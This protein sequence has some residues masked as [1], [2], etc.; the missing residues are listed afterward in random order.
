MSDTGTA[1]DEMP[2]ASS[3]SAQRRRPCRVHA[4]H[5]DPARLSTGA[6]RAPYGCADRSPVRASPD[7]RRAHSLVEMLVVLIIVGILIAIAVPAIQRTRE[8]ARQAQC[9]HNQGQLAKAVHLHIAHEPYGR[10][11]G[12]RAFASDG[13]TVI[14]WAPQVFEY[15]GRDDLPEDPTQATYVE[16]LVCPSD[17]RPKNAPRLNYVVNGGQPGSDNPADGIFFDHAKA[18][19]VYITKD[20]FRDGLTNT[21]ML[22][23]NRDVTSWDVTDEANQCI[24][25]PLTESNEINNGVGARPSSHHPGGFVAAFADGSVKFMSA[26]ELNDDPAVLTNDSLYVALL[27][28]GGDELHES[29]VVVEVDPCDPP[30]DTGAVNTGIQW[31]LNHQFEDGSWSL[32]HSTHPDCNGQCSGN[33]SAAPMYNAATALGLLPLLGAGSSPSSG[34]YRESVCEAVNFLLAKQGSDGSVWEVSNQ[35]KGMYSHLI[36]HLALAEA[37]ALAT[38]ADEGECVES[39]VCAV[40]LDELRVAVEKAT[41]YTVGAQAPYDPDHTTR[42]SKGGWRYV[43]QSDPAYGSAAPHFQGCISHHTWA[44]AALKATERAGLSVPAETYDR[45]AIFLDT[46]QGSPITDG[47]VTIGSEYAYNLDYS[48]SPWNQFRDR[49]TSMG[50]LSRVFLGTSTSHAA[51]SQFADRIV[52]STGG[53][54]Y[55]DMHCTQLMYAVGGSRWDQWKTALEANYGQWQATAA[56]GHAEGSWY[57]SPGGIEQWDNNIGGRHYVTVMALLCLEEHFKNLQ[58]GQ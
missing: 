45:A 53:D 49:T 2:K 57:T 30:D 55:W 37:L 3:S 38:A 35:N 39:T 40:D 1:H 13:A 42:T 17:H 44:L 18:E 6:F 43:W 21:I 19:R 54:V 32:A 48:S 5:H 7:L 51:I 16:L 14:G 20:D 58:L 26:Q 15:L 10:F 22:A 33:G 23:E 46:H 47:G 56:A 8:S 25:W 41:E 29:T 31:L 4:M 9:V 11:P 36:G 27:T 50:L 52:P 12:Y 24:L 34:Q 28:P